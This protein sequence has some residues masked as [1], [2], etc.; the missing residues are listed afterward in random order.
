MQSRRPAHGIQDVRIE[1]AA[2]AERTHRQNPSLPGNS[3]DAQRVVGYRS[4]NTD[5]ACSMPRAAGNRAVGERRV[6]QV[7]RSDPVAGIRGIGVPAVAVVGHGRIG[8]EVVARQQPV[9]RRGIQVRVVIANAGVHICDDQVVAPGGGVPGS[10]GV[11]RRRLRVLQIPLPRKI[12]VGRQRRMRIA[13]LIGDR[14]LHVRVSLQV[15]QSCSDALARRRLHLH[16]M[17]PGGD[18]PRLPPCQIRAQRQR[19]HH[20]LPLNLPLCI[21]SR[22]LH[23][24]AA[25][26]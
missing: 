25:G 14:V 3:R 26:S 15:R 12:S 7:G 23:L 9:E 6:L 21:G 2:L 19:L 4:E 10:H 20:C 24:R 11:N 16:G 1:S 22:R 8:D 13:P 18:F 5:H 17:Q